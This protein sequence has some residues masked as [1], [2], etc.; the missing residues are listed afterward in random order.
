MRGNKLLHVLDSYVL[1]LCLYILSCVWR[2][3]KLAC[4]PEKIGILKLV[5]IGDLT[6]ATSL[7]KDLRKTYPNAELHLFLGNDN[8]MLAD[9]LPVGGLKVTTLK[10]ADPLKN[11]FLIRKQKFDLFI[12]LG[13]WTRYEALLSGLCR[14]KRIIGFKTAGQ[15][16]HYLYTDC[17]EHDRHLQ[18]LENLQNMARLAGG[19]GQ[20]T[21]ELSCPAIDGIPDLVDLEAAVVFLHPWPSGIYR[22]LKEWPDD[23]WARLAL[24]LKQAGYQVYVTAGP[25]DRDRQDRLLRKFQAYNVDVID[26]CACLSLKELVWLFCHHPRLKLVSVN[27]GIMHMAATCGVP[28]VALNGPTNPKR[29]GAVGKNVVNITPPGHIKSGYLNLGFEYPDQKEPIMQYIAVTTVLRA[30]KYEPDHVPSL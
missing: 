6:L 11:I 24:S 18:Q 8:Y 27:T 23:H 29:W 17:V 12:D 28:T 14:A 5:A 15:K 10:I 1:P 20:E 2:K 4:V 19:C 30:L 7:L 25:D 16:R 21:A 22:E 3:K 13:D 9:M 26:L